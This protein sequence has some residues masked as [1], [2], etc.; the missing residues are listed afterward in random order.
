MPLLQKEFTNLKKK[1]EKK[2]LLK[3][4]LVTSKC[5][6]SL[7][8]YI[9]LAWK[10]KPVFTCQLHKCLDQPAHCVKSGQKQLSDLN[11]LPVSL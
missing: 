1:K 7:Y 11:D 10:R 2:E 3:F 4:V 9:I 6:P 5:L 8:M